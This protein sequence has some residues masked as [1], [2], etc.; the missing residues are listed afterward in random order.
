MEKING[1]IFIL[2][3]MNVDLF[4]NI[5]QARFDK[6]VTISLSRDFCGVIDT[7]SRK[8]RDGKE[9]SDIDYEQMIKLS[10]EGPLIYTDMLLGLLNYSAGYL[11]ANNGNEETLFEYHNLEGFEGINIL[12]DN[13]E[14]KSIQHGLK[15]DEKQK[16]LDLSIE[17][18][19]VQLRSINEKIKNE[20]KKIAKLNDRNPKKEKL[21][22]QS[23]TIIEQ[24]EKEKKEVMSRIF[25][26]S[27]RR[28]E[29]NEDYSDYSQLFRHLRNS[30]A[31]GRYE[32]EYD[33][34]LKVSDFNKIRFTFYDYN[35][36]NFDEENPDFKI[37]LTATQIMRIV[38]SVQNRVNTQLNK[39]KQM[40]KI[41]ETKMTDILGIEIDA[42]GIGIE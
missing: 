14:K 3:G 35:E 4:D 29:Y 23:R 21:E 15:G 13:N 10:F 24:K 12:S 25:K 33:R 22:L 36:D 2:N 18:Y 9:L 38:N 41:V 42:E 27:V 8:L 6:S 19:E 28:D 40:E 32:I 11:K 34:A 30:I 20:K 39:E 7:I 31:H 1:N 26:L 17:N 37:V 5:F 16:K